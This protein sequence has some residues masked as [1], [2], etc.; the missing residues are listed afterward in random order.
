[1]LNPRAQVSAVVRPA[2]A[3]EFAPRQ[4]GEWRSRELMRAAY[5]PNRM[6]RIATILAQQLTRLC[7]VDRRAFLRFR[8]AG[9]RHAARR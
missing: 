3:N 1:M 4:A 5:A 9:Q 6:T 7:R 2:P 8:C